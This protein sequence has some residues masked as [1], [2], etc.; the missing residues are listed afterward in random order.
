[1]GNACGKTR[2]DDEPY[3]P[4]FLHLLCR[5]YSSSTCLHLP[6]LAGSDRR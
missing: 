1:M 6:P 2:D 3:G 4:L 5:C